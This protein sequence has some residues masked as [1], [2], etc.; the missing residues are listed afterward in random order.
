MKNVFKRIISLFAISGL[1]LFLAS[2]AMASTEY[3]PND[4]TFDPSGTYV[5]LVVT[6]VPPA[7]NQ[8]VTDSNGNTNTAIEDNSNNSAVPDQ[9]NSTVN[10]VNTN[11]SNDNSNIA[12]V[13]STDSNSNSTTSGNSETGAGSDNNTTTNNKQNNNTNVGNQTDINNNADATSDTGNNNAGMNTGDGSVTTGNS[14]IAA[15][16]INLANTVIDGSKS[17]ALPVI[18][19][20]SDLIGDIIA[21]DNSSAPVLGS[22]LNLFQIVSN[23]LTGNGSD[24]S[25]I[26]NN[27]LGNSRITDNNANTDN[28]LNLSANSGQNTTLMN[29]GNGDVVTG[30]ANVAANV[31]NFLN[32]S[33]LASSWWMGMVNVFGNWMGNLVLP[34]LTGSNGSVTSNQS[35]TN[36]QTGADSDNVSIIN[37]NNGTDQT[38]NN[39]ANLIDNVTANGN[40]GDNQS[41]ANTGSGSIKSG[42]VNIKDNKL[43]FA[44]NTVVGNQWWMMIINSLHGWSGAL[45]GSPDG[46]MQLVS[47]SQLQ[48]ADNSQ[49]GAGSDNFATINNDNSSTTTVNNTANVGNMLELSANT[50]GNKAS[51][52]TG[53]GDIKTG[54]ANILSNLISFANNTF[55]VQNWAMGIINVFGNWFGDAQM[56]NTALGLNTVVTT[57]SSDINVQNQNTGAGSDNS[58]AINDTANSQLKI[59]NDLNIEKTLTVNVN[60]GR[61]KSDINTGN[62]DIQSGNIKTEINDRAV[63]NGLFLPVAFLASDSNANLAAKNSN[64]GSDS[65]N[66]SL[67][68]FLKNMKIVICNKVNMVKNVAANLNTGDNE[69]DMNTGSSSIVTGNIDFKFNESDKFNFIKAVI[70]KTPSNPP[71]E[72]PEQE[73]GSGGGGALIATDLGNVLPRAGA[74]G[75]LELALLGLTAAGTIWA[76]RR[77]Q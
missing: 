65:D 54:D 34:S 39:N 64:T 62:S 52:N 68:N 69:A 51:Y 20:F 23:F 26:V 14:D 58:A 12:T 67:I 35:A 76:I 73:Y 55:H 10:G 17:M 18:N 9:S 61:N 6:V 22:D 30:N 42:D 41:L 38:I 5:P 13:D 71:E 37:N 66:N 43:T 77:R 49:T 11:S 28:N 27:N 56:D 63:G 47:V 72:K 44:N 7:E 1:A 19:Y 24:N 53:S 48:S 2:P 57:G 70:P 8:T 16:I 15:N 32:T 50:G 75:L 74:D 46:T 31:V 59:N 33:V 25:S 4:S 45:I 3:D 40:T 36:G 29:T 60:T 21:G